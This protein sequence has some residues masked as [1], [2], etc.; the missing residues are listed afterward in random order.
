[1]NC[2]AWCPKSSSNLRPL[3]TCNGHTEIAIN[4]WWLISRAARALA[5]FRHPCMGIATIEDKNVCLRAWLLVGWCSEIN[6]FEFTAQWTTGIEEVFAFFCLVELLNINI[7]IIAWARTF[8]LALT[9]QMRSIVSVFLWSTPL[10]DLVLAV[11]HI[12]VAM[13]E[14]VSAKVVRI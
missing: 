10:I 14:K 6:L 8:F 2:L 5:S 12:I 3:S 4:I 11:L 9:T 1:M 7:S 13:K